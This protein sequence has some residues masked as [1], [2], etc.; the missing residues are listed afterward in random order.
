MFA[1]K[2]AIAPQIWLNTPY[3]QA[4]TLEKL[5]SEIRKTGTVATLHRYT[6]VDTFEDLNAFLR[7]I[8][9]G[10]VVGKEQDDLVKFCSDIVAKNL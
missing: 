9:S 5:L 4:D 1:G 2:K 7:E 10:R 3:S 8:K 6:D